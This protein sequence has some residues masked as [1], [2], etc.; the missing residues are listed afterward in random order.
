[1]IIFGF[2]SF[3]IKFT[4]NGLILLRKINFISKGFQISLC[5]VIRKGI[6]EQLCY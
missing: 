5:K 1:M 3:P 6:N 2:L 4:Y